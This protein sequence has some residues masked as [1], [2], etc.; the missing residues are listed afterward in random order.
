MVQPGDIK[1]PARAATGARHNDDT[2]CLGNGARMRLD[3]DVD[4]TAVQ[5]AAI[6]KGNSDATPLCKDCFDLTLQLG[7]RLDVDFALDG[8]ERELLCEG[9]HLEARM[10]DVPFRLEGGEPAQGP[11]PQF[12][13]LRLR[14]LG[15]ESIVSPRVL[16][17]W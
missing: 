9:A 3:E 16:S 14:R 12:E 10:H 11:L 6:F 17:R 8:D 2:Q 15:F 7:R 1:N 5:I 13:A 4:H